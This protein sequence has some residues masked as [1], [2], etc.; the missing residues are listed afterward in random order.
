MY[1]YFLLSLDTPESGTIKRAI[2]SK[3]RCPTCQKM[4]LGYR[5]LARHFDAFPDHGSMENVP[6]NPTPSVAVGKWLF[7]LHCCWCLDNLL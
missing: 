1:I 5:R 7:I 3:F 4:Y 2:H 6:K